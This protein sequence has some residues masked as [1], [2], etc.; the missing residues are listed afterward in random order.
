M[1]DTPRTDADQWTIPDY[2]PRI[3]DVV[4]V[5][6]ARKLERE[7]AKLREALKEAIKDADAFHD[8]EHGKP[9]PNLNA[10]RAIM[11]EP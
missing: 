10:A 3:A 4:Y 11:E 1:S 2:D 9:S 8:D 5:E 6:F 7:N